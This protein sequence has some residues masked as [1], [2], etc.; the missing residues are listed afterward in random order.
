MKKL[1]VFMLFA[2]VFNSCKKDDPENISDRTKFIGTW[3]GEVN[4]TVTSNGTIIQTSTTV[5]SETISIGSETNEILIKASSTEILR[6]EVSGDIFTIE[7]QNLSVPA[8]DGSKVSVST[9]GMGSLTNNVLKITYT[10]N[11]TYKSIPVRWDIV[12]T[13]TK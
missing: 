10:M 4:Q 11:G 5:G 6:A 1:L 9:T 2:V 13:L 3:T 8:D 7:N 12:K